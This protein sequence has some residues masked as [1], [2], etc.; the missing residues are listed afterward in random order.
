[1][2]SQSGEFERI[3]SHHTADVNGVRLHYVRGGQGDPIVLL[4]GW[5]QTWYEWRHVMPGLAQQYT[6]IAPDLRGMG[7]SEIA[8]NGYDKRT[9]A[10]DIYELVRQLGFRQILLVGH[11]LGGQVAYAYACDRP[12]DVSRLAILEAPIPGLPGWEEAKA[13]TWHFAFH[14]IPDLPEALVEGKERFYLSWFYRHYA[15]NPN[16]IAP[17]D[18]DEYVRT[19][20]APGKMQAGFD[21]YRA[22]SEDAKHNQKFV[23]AKL[24]MPVL[25][26]G[27]E[28]CLNDFP[29]RQLETVAINIRGGGIPRAGHWIAE[30][31]PDY[32]NQELFNF[33]NEGKPLE[34]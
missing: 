26:L 15:H 14:S 10:S 30:E 6:V 9:L 7:D 20:S 34:I 2:T 18:I 32:L 25:A 16:A 33:F 13:A 11:D 31:C 19:Y 28:D 22:F 23:D 21:Y 5:P 8:A 27:G 4:H 24:E 17:E 3:F 29:L 1:M 12:Q